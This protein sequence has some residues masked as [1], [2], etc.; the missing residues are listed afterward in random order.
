M[1]KNTLHKLK[2]C[3]VQFWYQYIYGWF[4]WQDAICWA[5]EYHPAWVQFAKTSR[6]KETRAYYRAK[7]LA[8]YRGEEE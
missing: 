2:T 7:I 8:A 5:K 3:L 6:H 4:E 1:L